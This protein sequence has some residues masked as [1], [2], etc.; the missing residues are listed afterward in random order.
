MKRLFSLLV[1]GL[2][3]PAMS[4][5]EVPSVLPIQG[6]LTDKAGSPIDGEIAMTFSL[7]ENATTPTA[8][9]S[10]SRP[11][12]VIE[13]HF[14]IYLG[15][16]SPLALAMIA[17]HHGLWLSVA[18]GDD[19][20]MPRIG[21][22]T[23]PYAAYAER[24]GNLPPHTHGPAEVSGVA[25]SGTKCAIGQVVT[26]FT[27]SGTP[28]CEPIPSG[29]GGGTTYS[30]A[31]FALSGQSCAPGQMMT[32]IGPTGLIVCSPVPQNGGGG[33]NNGGGISGSGK[34]GKIAVFE[35]VNALESSVITQYNNRIGINENY[36]ARTVEIN[37][38]LEVTGDFYWGGN[39]FTTSSCLIVGGTSC[40]T[41]CSKHK[42]SCY[43][44]FAIDKD[45]DSTSCGQSGFK[46][47]CCKN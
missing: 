18:V 8:L 20:A 3:L 42:M 37:G 10:E 2:C 31:D 46:F 26:G 45:S 7:Y 30:G 32:G 11:V 5:A 9:W 34:D 14:T 44:A 12:A 47:C 13:G 27:A 28:I 24:V 33:N 43:K 23:V 35:G 38:D 4:F 41:A 15:E 21:L 29:G 40:S 17:D 19:P 16:I 6:V 22:G 39:L 1:L 25:L 36:P